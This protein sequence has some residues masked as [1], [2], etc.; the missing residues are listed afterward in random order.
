MLD[1]LIDFYTGEFLTSNRTEM[2]KTA[3]DQCLENIRFSIRLGQALIM[4]EAD[5]LSFATLLS[6]FLSS[7]FLFY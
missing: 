4:K 3:S 5:C 2:D 7:L 6:H 1:H